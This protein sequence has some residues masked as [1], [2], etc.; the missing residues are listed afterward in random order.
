VEFK[1]ILEIIKKYKSGSDYFYS[2]KIEGKHSPNNTRNYCDSWGV[3]E[4]SSLELKKEAR[5]LIFDIN[6]EEVEG[7]IY[8]Q[9]EERNNLCQFTP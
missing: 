2:S 5:R 9:K 1:K 4:F 8:T 3:Y 6:S 7:I